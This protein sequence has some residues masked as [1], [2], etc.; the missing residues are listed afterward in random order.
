[1]RFFSYKSYYYSVLEIL[2][3]VCVCVCVC[4]CVH[5]KSCL[6]RSSLFWVVTQHMLVVFT[7]VSDSVQIPP[8]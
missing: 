3:S 6:F 7:D 5:V 8:H 4:V 1:M 2:L